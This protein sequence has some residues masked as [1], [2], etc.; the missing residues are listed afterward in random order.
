M[1]VLGHAQ[2]DPW[3]IDGFRSRSNDFNNIKLKDLKP[4][5]AEIFRKENAFRVQILPEKKSVSR[6][7]DDEIIMFLRF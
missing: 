5:A 6:T 1:M 4:L 2:S 3:G 7:V